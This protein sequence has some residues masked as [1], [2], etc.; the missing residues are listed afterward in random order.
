MNS[1]RIIAAGFAAALVLFGT[2]GAFGQVLSVTTD[3]QLWLKAD[4]GVTLNS[5]GG[6]AQWDD[7]SGNANHAVQATET[8]A[9]AN[10]P[11]AQNGRPVLR[12]DGVDDYLSVA[13]SASLSFAGDLTT[14]F[15]VRFSDFATYRAVWA[16]TA[17]NLPAPTD[18]YTLPGS[19]RPQVYR[20]NG[21][22]ASLG[23]YASPVAL[24][25]GSYLTVGF[26]MEGTTCTHYLASQPT[27]SGTIAAMTAD[28]G[29]PVLI[30]TRGDLFTKMKGE[31]AEILIYSRALTAL[32]RAAVADYLAQKYGIANFPPTA[33]LAVTP[34]GP[35]HAQGDELTLTATASDSDGTVTA[36]QFFANGTLLGTATA[37]P[38]K[39]RATL[40]SSGTYVLTA[41]AIDNKNASGDSAPVTRTVTPS[42]TPP[43]L[44]ITSSLQLWLKADAGVTPDLNGN[45]GSWDDQS[46]KGNNALAP[47]TSTAPGV[48]LAA[49]NTL[50]AIHFDG[51]DDRLDV[52]D[53]PS[54]SI[55]GDLTTFFVVRM[56][57][58][59]T[60]RAVWAKTGGPGG[61]LPAPTDYYALPNSGIP[62]AIRGDGTP[63]SIGN[64]TGTRALRAG[65]FDLVGFSVS[66]ASL[67]HYLNG[68]PNGSGSVPTLTADADTPLYIGTRQDQFTRMKGDLAEVLIYDTAL[69]NADRHDV[70]VYLARRY[71]LP[72]VTAVNDAPTVALTAPAPATVVVAP[73]DLVVSADASDADGAVLRVDFLINGGLAASDT[74]APYSA[75]VTFPIAAPAVIQARA[76]DNLGAVTLSAPVS[77]TVNETQAIPLP[78]RSNLRLW[79][80]ADKGVTDVGGDVTAWRDQS[81]NF[82]NPIQNDIPKRPVL[83]ASAV[84]GQPAIRFDGADDSLVAPSSPT[85]AITGDIS[86]FF[87]VRIADFDTFRAVWAKTQNNLPASTDFYTVPGT[88]R[89]RVYRGNGGASLGFSDATLSPAAD[90]FVIIAFDQTGTTVHH[91]LNGEPNGSGEIPARLGDTGTPLYIGTR[92]DQFTRMKGDIAEII[93]Y[94]SGLS[95]GDRT[96]VFSYLGRRYGIATAPALSIVNNFDGTVTVSWPAAVTGWDLQIAPDP[97][98]PWDT[99]TFGVI[100]NTFIDFIASQTFYRLR[101]Q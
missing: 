74:T 19:G 44:G 92:D 32:E 18:F 55:T 52:A 63:D 83:V 57:D 47:D 2:N 69:S 72:L 56:D 33:T 66:G 76:I 41:R 1:R 15:V 35:T 53:S 3:L 85:M 62:N 49:L 27:G 93:I 25:A 43:T 30:G 11:N 48:S 40:E 4:A 51:V 95:D 87:V 61:N 88:G 22:T 39:I 42:V 36:V 67:S 75:T 86:T 34:A 37:P 84:N 6:V 90:Q 20:G 17:G 54:V 64:V 94:D 89:P 65:Q 98:G 73:G 10:V 79:L 21:T 68:L 13:S 24:T 70:Q 78:A 100:N 71:A 101:K 23:A 14:F 99:V 58:F 5:S 50:P 16:K 45:V 31:I 77:I 46:G 8:L 29:A 38:Y 97:S 59:A 9:P 96:T 12:F 26:S 91:Y 82:N 28:T 81:G 60:F 80:R 7:Q